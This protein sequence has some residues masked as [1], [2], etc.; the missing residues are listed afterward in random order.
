MSTECKLTLSS[1]VN[2]YTEGQVRSEIRWIEGERKKVQEEMKRRPSKIRHL[3]DLNRQLLQKYEILERGGLPRESF[4]L[5]IQ[6][7]L[8]KRAGAGS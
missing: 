3:N 2:G 7:M 5:E 4:P 6:E 1:R 8:E